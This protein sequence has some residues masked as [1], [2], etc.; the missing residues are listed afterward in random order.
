MRN[1]VQT[2]DVLTIPAP[3]AVSSGAVIIAGALKGV[4]AGDAASGAQVDVSTRGVFDIP[5]VAADVFA[6]GDTVYFDEATNLAT[7]TATGNAEIGFAVAAAGDG[8]AS[9]RVKFNG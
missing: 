6:V 2:G 8:A 5:K 1:F 7:V 4:A 3:A 9:V